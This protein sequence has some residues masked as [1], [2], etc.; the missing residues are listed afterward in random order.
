MWSHI[1]MSGGSALDLILAQVT[2]H[3]T[4]GGRYP[5]AHCTGEETD[6]SVEGPK[7]IRAQET[8]NCLI[9]HSE[10]S[11]EVL[12]DPRGCKTLTC[13]FSPSSFGSTLLHPWLTVTGP[14]AISPRETLPLLARRPERCA[15]PKKE[16]LG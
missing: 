16:G 8:G 14:K 2:S 1:Q 4:S 9:P 3:R 7:E 13:S 11:S 10:L 15:P 5:Y 12:L 6:L